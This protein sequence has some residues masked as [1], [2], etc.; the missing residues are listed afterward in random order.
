MVS[1]NYEV[2]K[3]ILILVLLAIATGTYAINPNVYYAYSQLSKES[4]L[5]Y[6]SEYV[7][8]RTS[9]TSELEAVFAETK[10]KFKSAIKRENGVSFDDAI[11]YN[12]KAVKSILSRSQYKK[13]LQMISSSI[14]NPN[15]G[16]LT[17][18]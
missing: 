1:L 6:V 8:A 5:R 7:N 15:E 4:T 13:Y 2:M 11:D 14:K 12:L 17:L 3:K 9:Q 10:Q 18:E 16:L